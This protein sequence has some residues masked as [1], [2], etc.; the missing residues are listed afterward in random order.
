MPDNVPLLIILTDT[1]L[2]TLLEQSRRVAVLGIKPESRADRPAHFVPA[3][4]AAAGY[5]V[6]PVPVYYPDLTRILRQPVYRSLEAV[7]GG[8]DIAV[9]FRRS[10]QLPQHVTDIIAKRP[11]V[12]WFQSGIRNDGVARELSSAGIAVVQD[13]CIMVEHQRL[14]RTGRQ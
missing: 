11:Q 2:R 1:Q 7:P 4:L 10:E 3:Y 13:R 12:V 5:E 6:I 14:L 9:V 8:V